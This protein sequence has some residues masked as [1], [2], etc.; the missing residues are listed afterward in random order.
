V[1]HE[2][3]IT[4]PLS[5]KE[6]ERETALRKRFAEYWSNATGEPRAAFDTFIS[7]T[8]IADGVSFERVG[9]ADAHGW[10]ARP[11]T[12]RDGDAILHIHGGGYVQGS[13]DA[14]RAL[15]SQIAMRTQRSVFVL[16]YPLA[17]EATVPTAFDSVV[18]AYEWLRAK[19]APRVALVGDSAGGGLALALL[20]RLDPASQALA[21][22][23]FS[24]W[25]DLAFTGASMTDDA[26]ADPLITYEHLQ[27]YARKYL[28]PT[29]PHDPIAS[30]LYGDLSNLPPLL[31]QVGSDERLFDDARQ[32]AR[33]ATSTGSPVLLEIW[34]AMHHVF[35]L[36]VADL[37]ASRVALDRACEF[38]VDVFEL[39]LA[40]H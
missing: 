38:L 7:N 3:C 32:L 19:V 29:D 39:S 8:P 26:I 14:F 9:N 34:Q 2:L 22:V 15:A 33:R 27:D 12:A 30:P 10:W 28:G 23:L 6:R 13:A 35:Q 20:S 11:S 21:A 17:P 31:I 18:Q 16:D 40:R 25:V 4:F 5:E 1:H 36:N 24:P 37:R